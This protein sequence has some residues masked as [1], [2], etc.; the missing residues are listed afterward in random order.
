MIKLAV[1]SDLH[2]GF[3]VGTE[4]EEESFANAEQAFNLA[5]Q[6]EPHLIL[7][8]GDIFHDRIPRQETLGRAIELFSS[9][10]RRMSTKPVVLQSIKNQA[11]QNIKAQIPP[12]IAIWG[13][14][15]RR[16]IQSTNPVQILEK[17]GLLAC[18]HSESI[19]V[20]VGADRI[21]IHGLSGVPESIAKEALQSWEPEPFPNASNVM[22]LH[23]TFRELIPVIKEGLEFSELPKGFDLFL[24]GHIHWC[25]EMKQPTT[26]TPVIIPGST[27]VTQHTKTESQKEKGIYI[28]ELGRQKGKIEFVPI[29][30]RKFLYEVL[31]AGKLRPGE[32]M[33]KINEVIQR[34]LK[35]KYGLKPVLKI[36]IEGVLAEGFSPADLSVNSVIKEYKDRLIIAIDKSGVSS[37]TMEEQSKFLAEFKDKKLSI[38]QMGIELLRANLKAK[39]STK[40]IENIFHQLAEGNTELAEKEL[41]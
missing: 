29:K 31:D 16:H 30:S 41:E 7:I 32:V 23:Q 19:L 39:V 9:L 26:Q 27:I 20:E 14:H 34:C 18:L 22:M 40:S 15:E 8:P 24:L 6:H 1:I 36:K 37:T 33:I 3:G 11:V 10:K 21:G 35:Q 4:R 5:L 17:A 28:I 13:T 12:I 25:D 2:L 38:D